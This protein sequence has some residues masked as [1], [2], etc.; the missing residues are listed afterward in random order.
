MFEFYLT[1]CFNELI[2]AGLTKSKRFNA[3]DVIREISSKQDELSGDK[4][5]WSRQLLD[6]AISCNCDDLYAIYATLSQE[7]HGTPWLGEA[8]KFRAESMPQNQCCVMEFVLDSLNIPYS[9]VE[10]K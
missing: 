3:S 8:V 10:E 4:S 2:S 7:I 9:K 1:L 6:K 5:S